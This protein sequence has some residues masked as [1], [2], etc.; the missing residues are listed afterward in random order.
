MYGIPITHYV[1]A[2]ISTAMNPLT[3]LSNILSVEDKPKEN[4]YKTVMCKSWI[5]S[6][7]CSYGKKCRFAH[8]EHELR[9]PFSVIKPFTASLCLFDCESP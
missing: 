4:N 3:C 5:Q 2:T 8:G 7:S 6:G 1:R 9:Y